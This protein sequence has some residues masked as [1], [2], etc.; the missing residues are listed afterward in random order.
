MI[1]IPNRAG[2]YKIVNL[3]T[4]DFYIGSAANLR[5]RK[6]HHFHKL[7]HNKHVNKFLQEDYNDKERYG[8]DAFQFEVILLCEP[9]ECIALETQYIDE[10]APTYNQAPEAGSQKGFEHSDETKQL[11]SE[12]STGIKKGTG[13]KAQ[14]KLQELQEAIGAVDSGHTLASALVSTPNQPKRK[15]FDLNSMRNLAQYKD[16]T[17]EEWDVKSQEILLNLE[18][19]A[20]FEKLIEG[21]LKQFEEAYDLSDMKFNDLETLR[22]LCQAVI[23]LEIYEQRSFLMAQQEITGE[24]INLT[25][26]LEEWKN[27]LRVSISKLQDDL[28]ITRKTRKSEHSESVA[29]E[30]EKLQ[31]DAREFFEQKMAF[32]F[33]EGRNG[34]KDCDMLLSTTWF[35]YFEEDNQM[36][37][38]CKRCGHTT[39]LKSK[40]VLKSGARMSNKPNLLPEGL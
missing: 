16:L 13:K 19:N 21:K 5:T 20:D 14:K 37:L 36:S 38:H 7:K 3:V 25:S 34:D 2:V 12:R 33:C 40:D 17:D 32:L 26:K 4:G 30:I 24:S 27:N 31:A 18:P 29:E 6:N 8:P 11:I 10:L 35:L 1:T 28:K 39:K 23:F 9:E 22:A 15:M